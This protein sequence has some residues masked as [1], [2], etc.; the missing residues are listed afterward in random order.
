MYDSIYVNNTQQTINKR[1][2]YNLSDFQ[3]SL[4]TGHKSDKVV[5]YYA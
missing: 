4:K 3:K 1:M 5:A 2:G